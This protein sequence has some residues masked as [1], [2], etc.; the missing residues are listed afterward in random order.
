M[1][2]DICEFVSIDEIDPL[3]FR[4]GYYLLPRSGAEKPYRLLLEALEK[5]GRVAIAKIVVRDKQH[6]ACVRPGK[7]VL[8]LETMFTPTSYGSP[9]TCRGPACATLRPRWRSR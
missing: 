8:L 7:R 1:P 4:K 3:F 5:T 6:L 2:I 9:T